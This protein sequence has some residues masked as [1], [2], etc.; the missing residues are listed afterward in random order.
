MATRLYPMSSAND[1]M[2]IFAG[3]P[4]GTNEILEALE[5]QGKDL[6]DEDQYNLIQTNPDAAKLESFQLFG[7]G[8]LQAVE[9]IRS[10]FMDSVSGRTSD[11]AL[12]RQICREQGN[13][14]EATIDRLIAEGG[15]CWC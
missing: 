1:I 3:V 5:A 11:P 14:D 12:V 4:A 2:E 15:V 9:T 13:I 7:Y 10:N 8:R 6:C